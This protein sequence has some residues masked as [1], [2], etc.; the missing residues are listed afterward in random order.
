MDT[1]TAL[2]RRCPP[3]QA[4]TVIAMGSHT[5]DARELDGRTLHGARNVVED[6]RTATREAADISDAFSAGDISDL[7]PLHEIATGHRPVQSGR[8]RVLRSGG[9][10]WEDLVIAKTVLQNWRFVQE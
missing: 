3:E 1:D 7:V 6:V 5:P 4:A 8:R 2:P 9:M 10:A